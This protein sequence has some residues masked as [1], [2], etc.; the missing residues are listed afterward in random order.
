M[1]EIRE[2]YHP[3]QKNCAAVTINVSLYEWIKKEHPWP[4]VLAFH[5]GLTPAQQ[6][7]LRPLLADKLRSSNGRHGN[8]GTYTSTIDWNLR[9]ALWCSFHRNAL[10]LDNDERGCVHISPTFIGHCTADTG[11]KAFTLTSRQMNCRGFSL[12]TDWHPRLD[13]IGYGKYSLLPQTHTLADCNCLKI[14]C[15]WS[16]LSK[17]CRH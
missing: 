8:G 7:R 13:L 6:K 14:P 3:T 10:T 16:L 2:V 1:W 17:L 5:R 9:L 15:I 11:M 12:T 4:R